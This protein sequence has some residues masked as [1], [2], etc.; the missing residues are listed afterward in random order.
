MSALIRITRA[1]WRDE[2][3]ATLVELGMVMPAFLLLFFGIIDFGRLSFHVVTA[4]K[5]LQIAA[6]IA[7]VRPPACD[8]VA[9]INTVGV[10][11]NGEIAPKYGTNCRAGSTVCSQPSDVTCAGDETN[12]TVAEIWPLISGALPIGATAADLQFTYASDPNLGFLGGPFVP[13][14]TVTLTN[15]TF[16]FVS[17]LGTL[18]GMT[19]AA[20]NPDLPAMSIPFPDLSVSLPAEDLATGNTG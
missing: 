20:D 2:R 9:V 3:G 15:Q 4:E 19:G 8:G 13:V 16:T 14:L 10:V 11:P 1:F 7:A 18:A 6:R 5:A 17:P 12:D